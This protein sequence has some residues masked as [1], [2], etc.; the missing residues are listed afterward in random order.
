MMDV[1]VEYKTCTACKGTGNHKGVSDEERAEIESVL[2][3]VTSYACPR[4]KGKGE[5]EIIPPAPTNQLTVVELIAL[6]NSIEDKSLPVDIEGCDC[7]GEAND[8]E[9]AKDSVMIT[10]R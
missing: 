10:R 7:I 2:P 4:C 6:L 8:V 9:V 1:D 5:V 3:D